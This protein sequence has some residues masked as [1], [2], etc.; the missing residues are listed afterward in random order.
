MKKEQSNQKR[1]FVHILLFVVVMMLLYIAIV[2]MTVSKVSKFNI[3]ITASKNYFLIAF[4]IS[5]GALAKNDKKEDIKTYYKNIIFRFFPIYFIMYILFLIFDSDALYNLKLIPIEAFGLQ[6]IINNNYSLFYNCIYIYSYIMFSYILYPFYDYLIDKI[7]VKKI[8]PI[9]LLIITSIYLFVS[10]NYQNVLFYFIL[11]IIGNNIDTLNLEK[12]LKN[13]ITKISFAA[14]SIII[15]FIL[16]FFK[17]NNILNYI[18]IPLIAVIIGIIDNFEMKKDIIKNNLVALYF[19]F[20]YLIVLNQNMIFKLF[21]IIKHARTI[22]IIGFIILISYFYNKLIS[23]Y[24]DK[25]NLFVK[26]KKRF[27]FVLLI[28]VLLPFLIGTTTH[29]L[30]EEITIKINNKNEIMEVNNYL[31]KG[32]TNGQKAFIYLN[33]KKIDSVEVKNN[34]FEYKIDEKLLKEG[35]NYIEVAG[36][37]APNIYSERLGG[38]INNIKDQPDVFIPDEFLITARRMNLSRRGKYVLDSNY[39]YNKNY[40]GAG[41]LSEGEG[42]YF[43]NNKIPLVKRNGV[44]YYNPVHISAQALGLYKDY[45]DNKTDKNK[46]AFLHLADWFVENHIN[47]SLKYGIDFSFQNITINS[48]WSSGMA[49]GRALSVLARAYYLTNNKKYLQAGKKILDFMLS[50]ADEDLSKGTSKKLYDFTNK[51][52]E[53]K[54]FNDYRLFEEYVTNPSSYVLNGDLFALLGLYDWSRL[55]KNDYG[56]NQAKKGFYDGVKSIEVLLPYYDYYG[57]SS[58]DL[59]QYTNNYIPHLGSKYAHRCHLQ[60]LYILYTKTHSEKIKE[61]VDRF[62]SYYK[63]DFWIQSDKLYKG[64]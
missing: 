54:Q 45:L 52:E 29:Y 31:I 9:I 3:S 1:S 24:H 47:G 25:L 50:S 8:I 41:S 43:D 37:R 28:I 13:N 42:I 55:S 48:G 11:F 32:E 20:T 4:F 51:F 14:V 5:L 21:N 16:N 34:L 33:D 27:I 44:L 7:N 36:Y 46:K 2:D 18:F 17:V 39:D 64:N 59:L 57:W 6:P 15:I 60:L 23:K 26:N 12:Y 40:I 58:Y 56:S 53:L 63:D 22:F 62:E 30:R 49:Q 38:A 10:N 19:I 61:Y 35:W